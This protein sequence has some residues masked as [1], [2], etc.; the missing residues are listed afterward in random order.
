MKDITITKI[1]HSDSDC[2]YNSQVRCYINNQNKI[3]LSVQFEDDDP[4]FTVLNA[5]TAE[6]LARDI[7]KMVKELRNG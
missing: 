4:G 7:L 5:D 6:Q 3:Y 1:Y 2:D